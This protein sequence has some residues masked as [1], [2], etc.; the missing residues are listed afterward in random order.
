M[1]IQNGTHIPAAIC[2]T[3]YSAGALIASMTVTAGRSYRFNLSQIFSK[4][5][6]ALPYLSAHLEVA[7]IVNAVVRC[8]R[9][10]V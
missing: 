7:R 9:L 4:T 5:L 8:E 6:A 2:N 1:A 3:G 10:R